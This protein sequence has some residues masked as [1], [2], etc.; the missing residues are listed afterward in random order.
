[1]SAAVKLKSL[2]DLDS[3]VVK[4]LKLFSSG[5]LVLLSGPMGAGK[6]TL[7]SSVVKALGGDSSEV[8]S[9]TF[10][11]HHIYEVNG[12]VIDHMDLYR[13]ENDHDLLTSGFFEVLNES[14]N[15]SFIEWSDRLD[16][17]V[18]QKTRSHIYQLC[19]ELND[20]ERAISIK[21]LV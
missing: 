4:N 21:P 2:E 18:F 10:S 9:P 8:S 3:W 11:L 17:S 13:L 5:N 15:L 19:I 14:E 12:L 6:T 1:M 20:Q 16:I 7:V